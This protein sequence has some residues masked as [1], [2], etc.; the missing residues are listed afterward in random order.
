VKRCF[1]KKQ[2]GVKMN[3]KL[4]EKKTDEI[5]IKRE[6]LVKKE[7]PTVIEKEHKLEELKEETKRLLQN[8][9]KCRLNGLHAGLVFIPVQTN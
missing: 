3:E 4:L 8:K 6:K 9:I 7:K 5:E 1:R 2:E